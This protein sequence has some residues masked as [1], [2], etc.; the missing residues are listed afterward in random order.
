MESFN[1]F[2]GVTIY[3]SESVK[4]K[5]LENKISELETTLKSKDAKI[6]ELQT[7]VAKLNETI[8]SKSGEF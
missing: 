8:M 7:E 5:E 2:S 6:D 1:V 4:I 3:V